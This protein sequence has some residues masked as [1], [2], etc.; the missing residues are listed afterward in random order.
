MTRGGDCELL[1]EKKPNNVVVGG[2]ITHFFF[3][4]LIYLIKIVCFVSRN[5]VM[6][7]IDKFIARPAKFKM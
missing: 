5:V 1:V 4:L 7:A 2:I 6:C 3:F